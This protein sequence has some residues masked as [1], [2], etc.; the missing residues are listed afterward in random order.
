MTGPLR[1]TS[2][3]CIPEEVLTAFG[4]SSGF[5]NGGLANSFDMA[6]NGEGPSYSR[7]VDGSWDRIETGNPFESGASDTLCSRS[8]ELASTSSPAG[9]RYASLSPDAGIETLTVKG[10]SEASIFGGVVKAAQL[11]WLEP[12]L[13]VGTRSAPPCLSVRRLDLHPSW[14]TTT[15]RCVL[16]YRFELH[17]RSI[18]SLVTSWVTYLREV[19]RSRVAQQERSATR[20]LRVNSSAGPIT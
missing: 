4:A 19:T 14:R 13:L 2:W 17:R 8:T 9:V 10:V 6:V 5:S 15:L 16:V 7:N 11:A 1:I 20:R 18:R 3:G 12:A